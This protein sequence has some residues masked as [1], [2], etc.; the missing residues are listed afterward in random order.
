MIDEISISVKRQSALSFDGAT[1]LAF[2]VVFEKYNAAARVFSG[3]VN[4]VG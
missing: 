1:R 2:I 4:L 3:V